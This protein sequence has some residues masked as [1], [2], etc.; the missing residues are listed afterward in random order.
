M[1]AKWVYLQVVKLAG[2]VALQVKG[3]KE[4][5]DGV[6]LWCL[7]DSGAVNAMGVDV[8]PAWT[9]EVTELLFIY[10]VTTWDLKI[11]I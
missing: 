7:Q 11:Y 1:R 3:I 6:V 4:Q 10:S 2:G 5:G 8:R 9:L